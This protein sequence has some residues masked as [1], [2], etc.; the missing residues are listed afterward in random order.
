MK[1]RKD[2]LYLSLALAVLIVV[3]F[4]LMGRDSSGKAKGSATQIEVVEAIDRSY[5]KAVL[6]RL[7]EFKDFAVKPDLN[8][9]GNQNLFGN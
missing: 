4:L 5:D 3:V 8:N 6:T 7:Q 2:V 1:P 9:L